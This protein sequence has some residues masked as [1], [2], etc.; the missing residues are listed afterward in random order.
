MFLKCEPLNVGFN[1]DLKW[2]HSQRPFFTTTIHFSTHIESAPFVTERHFWRGS[3]CSFLAFWWYTFAPTTDPR[4]TVNLED[5]QHPP[6]PFFKKHGS[7]FWSL[8]VLPPLIFV[9]R[10]RRLRFFWFEAPDGIGPFAATMFRRVRWMVFCARFVLATV[11]DTAHQHRRRRA[12]ARTVAQETGWGEL[13]AVGRRFV[14]R[15][16][17]HAPHRM[18]ARSLSQCGKH[19]YYSHTDTHTHTLTIQGCGSAH[20]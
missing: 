3:S 12:R 2:L 9:T 8:T 1:I 13:C 16:D 10:R 5:T 11:A 7:L 14:H 6:L 20:C 4:T 18:L 17:H 19:A 15:T